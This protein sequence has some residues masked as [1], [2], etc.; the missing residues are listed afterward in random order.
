MPGVK[1]LLMQYKKGDLPTLNGSV[2]MTTASG[3]FGG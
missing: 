1:D 3:G 2:L